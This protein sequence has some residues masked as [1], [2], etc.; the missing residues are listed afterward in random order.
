M[1]WLPWGVVNING[2]DII[3]DTWTEYHNR[4]CENFSSFTGPRIDLGLILL[5]SNM[6]IYTRVL[7]D[8]LGVHWSDTLSYNTSLHSPF[9]L[10]Y[11][12]S[13][14]KVGEDQWKIWKK[15]QNFFL[16]FQKVDKT[17]WKAFGLSAWQPSFIWYVASHCLGVKS[18]DRHW[19]VR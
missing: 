5:I 13:F 2:L 17:S 6:I 14:E 18:V 15:Q 1:K 16:K 3:T 7:P 8:L 11:F 12:L 10:E 9:I 4:H 19:S